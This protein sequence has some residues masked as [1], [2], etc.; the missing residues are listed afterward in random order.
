MEPELETLRAIFRMNGYPENVIEKN[1]TS[2]DYVHRTFIGPDRCPVYIRLPWLGSRPA[3]LLEKKIKDSV[4]VA[5]Y[6]AKIC[7][8]YNTT[9]AFRLLKDRLSTHFSSNVIYE[10]E[11]QECDTRYVGRTSQH[12]IARIKQHVPRY[13]LP[14]A[15]KDK[16]RG[17][18]KRN[19]SPVDHQSAIASHLMQ[20]ESCRLKYD[21]NNFKVIARARNEYHL[22][23]L[24]AMYIHLFKPPLCKQKRFVADLKLF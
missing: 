2:Y 3:A 12:L 8:V 1:I 10:F 4:R 6:A 16:R 20:N 14:S 17:G 15:P 13:L 7:F 18:N 23:I 22:K 9:R 5:Y 11:C 21:D 24:E 19:D